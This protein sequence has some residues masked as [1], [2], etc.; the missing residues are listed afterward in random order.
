MIVTYQRLVELNACEKQ[1]DL[2]QQVFGASLELPTELEAQKNLA[3]L[4]QANNVDMCW[5]EDNLCCDDQRTHIYCLQDI[6]AKKYEKIVAP[7]WNAYYGPMLLEQHS[8][9]LFQD[10]LKV[11]RPAEIILARENWLAIIQV[12]TNTI[13]ND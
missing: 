13:N 1:R 8:E 9:D 7:Y 2:F 11:S 3:Y 5:V 12:L 6:A 4:L 10:Y